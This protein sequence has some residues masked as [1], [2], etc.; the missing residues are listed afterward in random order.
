[1]GVPKNMREELDKRDAL[2]LALEMLT[3]DQAC[4]QLALEAVVV[5]MAAVTKVKAAGVKAHIARQSKRF[6][7]HFEGES[8]SGFTE[9]AER[10]AKELTAPPKAKAMPKKLR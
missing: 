5:N 8:L 1:M 10:I 6:H 2:I 7:Q 3:V 9:R 4:R